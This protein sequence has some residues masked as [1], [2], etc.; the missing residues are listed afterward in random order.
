MQSVFVQSLH[1]RSRSLKALLANARFL[2][3]TLATAGLTAAAFLAALCGWE[4]ARKALHFNLVELPANQFWLFGSPP[5]PY[6]HSWRQLFFDRHVILCFLPTAL[7]LGLLL[8]LL[9]RTVRTPLRL[10]SD[11]RALAALMLTYAALTAIPLIGIL[12]RHY[13]YPQARV[14]ILLALLFIAE[15][16]RSRGIA[17]WTLPRWPA[18]ALSV[19]CLLA[20]G[21]LLVQAGS[22]ANQLAG[23]W[24]SSPAGADATLDEY[25]NTFM[26]G[27]TGVI[28]QHRTRPEVSLWSEYSALL[29]A[30]YGKLQTGEDYIIHA[31]GSDRWRHYVLAFRAANPEFV[32]TMTPQ[33]S[34]AEW[35]QDEHWEFYEEVLNNYRPIAEVEH[36]LIWQR[37]P[38]PWVYPAQTFQALA[39][40]RTSDRTA[41]QTVTLPVSAAREQIV[42][43]RVHYHVSNRWK[44]LPL[45]GATP[46]YLAT[47][48][49]SPRNNAISFSPD[50]TEF[51][52]P[53]KLPAGRPVTLRF[54]TDSLLPHV[55]FNVE[56]VEWKALPSQ[57]GVSQMFA[58]RV[59]PSRY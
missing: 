19:V 57:P 7:I 31:L 43:V 17:F 36:A 50:L 1:G 29:D 53:V 33:F 44:K 37:N 16:S 35:L 38:G 3:L 39:L 45:L 58:A 23:H 6:L 26:A 51:Q 20:G 8:V 48:E 9:A 47:V 24:R 14:A 15:L 30:H 55:A 54:E 34:F 11:W 46:R 41:A 4:G 12:S 32:T 28:E 18:V 2:A 27:A 10:G 56:E 13:T 40:N 49:G 52:F 22:A 5:M 21:A 42:V 59:T 25:W